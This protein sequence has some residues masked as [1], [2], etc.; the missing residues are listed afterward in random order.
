MAHHLED[1][2]VRDHDVRPDQR[3]DANLGRGLIRVQGVEPRTGLGRRDTCRGR[4][5]DSLS[6]RSVRRRGARSWGF[7]RG[8]CLYN[9]RS[10]R[11]GRRDRPG[12]SDRSGRRSRPRRVRRLGAGAGERAGRVRDGI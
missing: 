11:S 2:V 3:A 7:G 9:D 1:F 6:G 5:D 4:S 8:C 12:G 10:D